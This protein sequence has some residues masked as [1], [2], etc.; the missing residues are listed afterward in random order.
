MQ[1]YIYLCYIVYFTYMEYFFLAT[2]LEIGN[3]LMMFVRYVDASFYI[4]GCKMFD[5][6]DC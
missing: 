3:V 5:V 2:L 6:F 4:D 1:S